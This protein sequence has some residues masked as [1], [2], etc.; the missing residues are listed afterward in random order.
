ML[1]RSVASRLGVQMPICDGLYRI[2]YE[3][4]DARSLM[5]GLMSRPIKAEFE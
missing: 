1:F 3:G 5:Q 4:Q 2:L